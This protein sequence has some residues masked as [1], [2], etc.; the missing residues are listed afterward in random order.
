[1]SSIKTTSIL[2]TPIEFL[3]GV[4]PKKADLLKT[5]LQIFT[6]RDLLEHYPFR[7][8]DKSQ[9][10]RISEIQSDE[11]PLQVKGK[12]KSLKEVGVGNKK[13]LNALFED[14]TGE[15]ELAWFK[16]VQWVRNGLNYDEEFVVYGK[17]KRFKNTWSISHPEVTKVNEAKLKLTPF[18]PV[19]RSSEKCNRTGLNSQGIESIVINLLQLLRHQI[20]ETL[21]SEILEKYKLPSKEE[22]SI[23]LHRPRALAL[24]QRS[25]TRLKLEELLFLQLILVSNKVKVTTKMKGVT[26]KKVGKLFTEFYE[27]GIPFDL[28]GAQK[29]VLKE[30]RRD[31]RYGAHM[32]RL[33]QGDVGSGKT[34]VALLTALLGIDNNYQVCLM[35]PTEILAIQHF[36]GISELLKNFPITVKLLTGNTPKSKRKVIHEELASG[37]LQFLIG[38]HALLEPVVMFK[39]LGLAIIDEQHR[40]GVKQRARLWGKAEIT[41][42][43]LVMTATPIPRT[44]AMTLYGDLDVSTIDELPPG[45]K[46]ITTVHKTDSSRLHVFGFME[47]EIKKGRQVYVVY[48]LI[49]ESESELLSELKDLYDGHEALEKRFPRP[50]YQISIVHGRQKSSDKE[51]E[52]NRFIKKE[53][54]ILVA[55]TVIEVGVNVPN[56]SVMVIENAERFGLSQLHQLRGRVGR[57]AEQSHCILMTGKLKSPESKRRIQTMCSTND[58]FEIAQVDLEIRGPGDIM[59]T[60]QSGA[61]DLK[62]A[63]LAVDQKILAKA[64]ELAVN[65]L[66]DDEALAKPKHASLNLELQ[67]LKAFKPNWGN[68]S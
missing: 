24:L 34:I 64:R 49:E 50:E 55:T 60:Q 21:P 41:P 17:P 27:N 54:Q 20:P 5:E 62:I 45:R 43:V 12:F 32:N 44:L 38:T 18:K 13:R 56:A 28:T 63:D 61:L 6:Y 14:E 53:T 65:I 33:I 26:F 31:V 57:G 48:P 19:Y 39:N 11:L 37:A 36:E 51:Y 2:G 15:I 30:V 40:F 16:G 1:M 47:E 35:A 4:G 29:R 67:R 23:H 8:I 22:A 42:H 10:H 9:F 25:L 7:Y 59:G 66:N 52:M 46:P 58:G 68:I 3:K